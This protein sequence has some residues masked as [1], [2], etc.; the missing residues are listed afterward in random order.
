MFLMCCITIGG[1][2]GAGRSI[3]TNSNVARSARS[4]TTATTTVRQKKANT[5]SRAATTD[6]SKVTSRGAATSVISRKKPTQTTVSRTGLFFS[7]IKNKQVV[8]RAAT[9]NTTVTPTPGFGAD[10]ETCRDAYF[11]CMDQFCANMD[12]TYRRCICSSRLTEIKQKQSAISTSTDSLANFKDLNLEVINK[13]AAEVRAM[14]SETAGE[15]VAAS[16]KDKSDSAAQLSAIGD[17]LNNTKTKALSTAGTLDAGGDIKAI[18]ATTDLAG[19]ANIANLTGEPLYNAVNAQ[20]AAMVTEQC[21][22]SV[23]N[24]VVSAYGMY[25]ENDCS[26][27]ASDLSKKKNT[28]NSAIRETGRDVNVARLE[29]Y[30]A[31]NSL[32]INECI[33]SVRQDLTA[34]TACGPDFIHCWDVTGLYLTI[35][36]GEPIYSSIFY[37]LENQISLSGNILNNQTNHMIVDALNDKKIFAQG[38]LDKCRD[39]SGD[40]WDEFMRQAIIEI[41]QKQQEQI[42]TVKTECLGVVNQCYD[43]QTNQLKKFNDSADKTLLG[44]TME[45]VE[46]LCQEKLNTCSNLYGG[47]PDGLDKLVNAMRN[48][49]DQRIV[50]ECQTLLTEFGQN[51]CMVASTDAIHSYPYT[52]RVYTPGDQKYAKCTT[53]AQSTEPPFYQH[54]Y[55][56]CKGYDKDSLYSQFV[57]YAIQVCI[58]PSEYENLEDNNGLY[59]I[60]TSVL[61]DINIVMGKLR[62]AMTN[63]LSAECERMGGIW[64]TTPYDA[65]DTSVTLLEQFYIDTGSDKQWGYCKK[66]TQAAQTYTLTLVIDPTADISY[67]S[68]VTYG[69][70]TPT[71]STGSSTPC[72]PNPC[73]T[74]RGQQQQCTADTHSNTARG[75]YSGENGTGTKYFNENGVPVLKTWNIASDMTL[76]WNKGSYTCSS[77]N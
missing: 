1:A 63:E 56:Q 2:N 15:A 7:P 14:M 5:V 18:W 36:K 53:K 51:V 3:S 9:V 77:S 47:G 37:N 70:A 76:Y 6:N 16:A 69:A 32:S 38:S 46:D 20:C 59:Q 65:T 74:P 4:Q 60:P 75:Y 61:Q 27:L 42:K 31:H 23:L 13:S 40:I 73:P 26:A 35:D 44:M 43:E 25:I 24:M 67:T 49:V 62:I 48:I 11:A 12:E 54:I 41:H 22:S 57:N 19:G 72:S 55:D 50:A 64:V 17:V 68:V 28:T 39:L 21:T 71:V 33:A 52:C 66:P 10:Y 30:D 58:R 45:T 34:E 8:G 29:N